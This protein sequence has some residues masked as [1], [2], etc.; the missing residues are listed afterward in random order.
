L[1]FGG[2]RKKYSLTQNPAD[3]GD[4]FG[5]PGKAPHFRM[6][7]PRFVRF[8]IVGAGAV[9]LN[10][11]LFLLLVGVVGITYIP[12]T[13]II[14]IVGNGFGFIANR[15]WT[16]KRTD[17]TGHRMLRYYGTMAVSLGMNLLSM[18]V[19]VEVLR[20]Y[21]LAAS[22][23]TS[24]WL[25]PLQYLAH[26]L[27]AFGGD[28]PRSPG[29]VMLATHYFANHGG[30]LELVADQLS[31]R[32]G[33]IQPIRWL[34][35]GPSP[36]PEDHGVTLVPVRCWNGF[37][38]RFGLPLP[39]PTPSALRVISSEVKAAPLVWV[40]D[41]IYPTNFIAAVAGLLRGKPVLVTVHVG[42]I[43]YRSRL[44]RLLMSAL[45][46]VS[47][48][49]VIRRAAAVAFVSER[50]KRDFEERWSIPRARLIPNGVDATVFFP[51]PPS[52]GE[53]LRDAMATHGAPV[54]LFVG[55][56]VERKGLP[57][58]HELA[59]R[60]P[61]VFWV[62]AGWGPLDPAA[63]SLA[64]VR[65]ERGRTGADLAA[66]YGA[67]DL[68]V[69]PSLGEGFPLVVQEAWAVGTRVLVDS[70]VVEGFPLVEG[71]IESE[72]ATGS[73]A[74]QRWAGR[75]RALVGEGI[76]RDER[77]KRVE[78]AHRHWNWDRAA[79]EY[80][81]IVRSLLASPADA[82]DRGARL[83]ASG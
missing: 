9:V 4:S 44:Q 23:I 19:L 62:F 28:R 12:A 61:D 56:F 14:F 30:G 20:I 21:Y 66:L 40:H 81:E 32:I 39:I 16:Y 77:A 83:Q 67:A 26:G 6:T 59:M 65:V 5:V 24:I 2:C 13:V 48:G 73:D 33:K 29:A 72:P 64:N 7:L 31:S 70:S 71:L 55:R 10:A 11:L 41:L 74:V 36:S 8:A 57:L 37:E 42:A 35:A 78:F 69:L 17:R 27:L 1:P 34:A 50:V 47:Y 75:V 15:A 52:E 63:W 82:G 68:V 49:L 51:R 54:V 46:R 60:L 58:L 18:T 53:E 3:P 43:P 45:V 79:S 80:Q 22:V 38:R 76:D 25:A